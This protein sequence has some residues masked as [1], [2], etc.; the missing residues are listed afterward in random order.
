M[1]DPAEFYRSLRVS[2]AAMLGFGAVDHLTAEQAIRTDRALTLRLVVDHLQ[3]RQMQGGQIDVKEFVAA[4]EA[5]ERMVGGDPEQTTGPDHDAALLKVETMISNLIAADRH[6]EAASG[7]CERCGAPLVQ[8]GA[9]AEA[10]LSKAT[11]A[12]DLLA[13]AEISDPAGSDVQDSGACQPPLS[14]VV[15]VGCEPAPVEPALAAEPAPRPLTDI[16]KMDAANSKPVPSHY[17]KGAPEVWRP[18]IHLFCWAFLLI[19]A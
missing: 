3:G 16:E 14:A 19:M 7:I 1:N 8:S 13:E 11:H 5:L 12:S 4:S 10:V 15:T 6:K 18:F 17:L 9:A 2:T